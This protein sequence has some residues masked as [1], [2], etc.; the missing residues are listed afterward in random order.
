MSVLTDQKIADMVTTTLNKLGRGRWWQIAQ[1]LTEYYVMPRLLRKGN[2][3]I[4]NDGLGIQETLMNKTGGESKWVGLKEEDA[5][6]QIDVLDTLTVLW[7]RL[8]DNM[9]WERRQLL[10]NRGES[11]INDVIKPQRVAM[12]LRMA[13]A[14]EAAFFGAPDP[15]DIKKPWGLK[16][17]VVKNT[18]QGFNGGIPSGFSSVG[19]VSLTDTPTYKNWTD[20]YTDITKADLIKKLRKAHRRTNWRSPVKATGMKG[21]FGMRRQLWMN[22]ETISSIEDVGEGQNENLGRDVASMD[23]Q[24]VFKKHQLNYVPYLDADTTNPIYML[25]DT[26]ITPF[27]LKGDNLRESDARVSPRQHNSFEVHI[28][29]SMNFVMPNRRANTV[30]YVA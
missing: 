26:T 13:T 14:L 24:I 11:R 12:M 29:H 27:V 18:T 16:Y 7:C 6:N 23:D 28:D 1:E 19:G 22:E 9:S 10:E 30:L 5:L 15:S 17:W 8:T 3:R 21:D 25:D 2:V 20:T 4:V